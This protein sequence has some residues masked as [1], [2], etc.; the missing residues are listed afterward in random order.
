VIDA[1]NNNKKLI[2]YKNESIEF[3]KSKI[4]TYDLY[5]LC[6]SNEEAS[7]DAYAQAQ[8]YEKEF[9]EIVSKYYDL[10]LTS[11]FPPLG[12]FLYYIA[13]TNVFSAL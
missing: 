12:C 4:Y 13:K 8:A 3:L 6:M 7:S 10:K 9:Y 1:I 11:K 5:V 2:S